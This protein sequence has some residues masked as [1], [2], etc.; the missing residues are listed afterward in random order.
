MSNLSAVLITLLLLTAC[1]AHVYTNTHVRGGND[2]GQ[3]GESRPAYWH[4][5]GNSLPGLLD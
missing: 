2:Y 1:G 3:W 4:R 5:G